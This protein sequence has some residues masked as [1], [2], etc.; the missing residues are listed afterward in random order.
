MRIETTTEGWA[1]IPLLRLSA[2]GCARGLGCLLFATR[3]D[4]AVRTTQTLRT[5]HPAY[6]IH[7]QWVRF[8]RG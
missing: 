1:V 7:L 2:H 8:G 6:T 5:T 4:E 3:F